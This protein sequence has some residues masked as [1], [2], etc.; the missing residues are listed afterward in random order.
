MLLIYS[1]LYLKVRS[2]V[3]QRLSIWQ[4]ERTINTRYTRA[5]SIAV[6]CTVDGA[7]ETYRGRPSSSHGSL[8]TL[9]HTHAQNNNSNGGTHNHQMA[10]PM[11]SLNDEAI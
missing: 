7:T 8:H 10:I 2:A 1:V 9:S 11:L 4:E 3:R 5:T 6:T